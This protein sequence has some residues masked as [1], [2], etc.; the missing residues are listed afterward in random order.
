MI[1]R[2]DPLISTIFGD[3]EGRVTSFE[4]PQRVAFQFDRNWP[5]ELFFEVTPTKD[6]NAA[7]AMKSK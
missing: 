1:R 4:P 5:D 3:V 7:K 2:V 6:G